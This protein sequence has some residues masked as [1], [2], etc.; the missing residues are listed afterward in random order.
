M[1][2]GFLVRVLGEDLGY[3][4]PDLKVQRVPSGGYKQK[5]SFL[6]ALGAFYASSPGLS[7]KLKH[8]SLS[9]P[10]SP[11]PLPPTHQKTV[12][13][14]LPSG[15]FLSGFS[16]SH[17]MFPAQALHNSLDGREHLYKRP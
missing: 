14:G 17:A 9:L 4:C 7:L 6:P 13:S 10:L 16:F 11:S 2:G 1:G 15:F 5:Y 8:D 12:W 3:S